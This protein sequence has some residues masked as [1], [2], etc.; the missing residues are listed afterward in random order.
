MIADTLQTLVV[1]PFLSLTPEL[2]EDYDERTSLMA[3]RMLFNLIASL[4]A[5]AGAPEIV[6]SFPTPQQGYLFMGLIFGG[7]GALPF[8]AI[9]ISTKERKLTFSTPQH[10]GILKSLKSAWRNY[11][12]RIATIINLLNWVTFDLVALMLPFFIRY[13][14]AN[15]TPNYQVSVPI[16]G[17]LT[18]E[19]LIFLVLLGTAILALPLWSFAA[20]HW[21]KRSAYIAGMSF[22]ALVQIFL[23]AVQPNQITLILVF[24]LLA[25]ISVSTAHILPNALFPDVLEWDELIT[26]QR[27]D[28][29]YYGILN[30]IRKL[31]SALTIFIAL[32]ALAL[33]NYQAPPTDYAPHMQAPETISAIRILTGPGGALLLLGAITATF[34]YPVTRERHER[35]LTLLTKRRKI[36][37]LTATGH[38]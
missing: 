18:L 9:F 13:W 15:G 3:Y 30:L 22:W 23:F 24:S 37:A 21:N 11:P 28:G 1:V 32:Q 8:L 5:A 6:A 16:I 10:K 7:L 29:M 36:R 33:F 20:R 27:R 35:T 2:T 38:K 31:A 26:G 17:M 19:S 34:F 25:G 12:F 4:A 14:L